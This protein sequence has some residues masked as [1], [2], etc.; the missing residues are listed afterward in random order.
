MLKLNTHFNKFSVII[1]QIDNLALWL[2]IPS[3][4]ICN[5]LKDL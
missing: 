2:F 3:F 5:S 4:Y 1:K